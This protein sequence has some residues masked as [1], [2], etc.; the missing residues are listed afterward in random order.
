VPHVGGPCVKTREKSG[1]T[2]NREEL[3]GFI[4]LRIRWQIAWLSSIFFLNR[5]ERPARFSPVHPHPQAMSENPR[6]KYAILFPPVKYHHFTF[7]T[8]S[9]HI[10]NPLFTLSPLNLV[11]ALHDLPFK[12]YSVLKVFHLLPLF[13]LFLFF[14]CLVNGIFGFLSSRR[15]ERYQEYPSGIFGSEVMA[16]RRFSILPTSLAHFYVCSLLNYE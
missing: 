6:F 15:V 5:P 14:P 1:N 10:R 11:S 7:S 4:Q 8:I 12:S 16:S 9:A 3:E 13:T 2:C